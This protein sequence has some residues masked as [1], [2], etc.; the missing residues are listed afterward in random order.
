MAALGTT[1]YDERGMNAGAV[2]AGP[3]PDAED[4]KAAAETDREQR[5]IERLRSKG[6]EYLANEVHWRFLLAAYEG[7]PNYVTEETLFKHQREHTRDFADRMKRA[8]YQNYCQPLVDFVPEYIFSQ[9]V[10]R[11]P[12]PEL[13]AQFDSFKKNCDRSGS[14]LDDFMQS[15]GE[16][17]RIF[18]MSFIQVDKLPTPDGI[19]ARSL[20][21]K[22]AAELGLDAPYFIAIRPLEVLKWSTDAIGNY[23]YLKRCEYLEVN[24]L[25]GATSYL[26]RYTEWT[27]DFFQISIVDV[28]DRD[29][30][31]MKQYATKTPHKWKEIPFVPVFFKRSK[32][33]NDVGQSLLQDIG[34]QNRHVF[35][36]TSLLDE[37]LY[38][39]CFNMLVMPVKSQVPT[40]E[41]V[42]GDMGTSNVLEIP[43]DAQHKPEYLSPP[44][45]PAEFIQAERASTIHEM[46]RQAAQDI[47]Q[48]LATTASGDASKQSFSRTVPVINKTADTLEHAERRAFRLWAIMQGKTF[49]D[50]KVS[51]KDDYS[52]TNLLDLLIQ[53]GMIFGNCKMQSP[54]FIR[55]E[56]K[57]IVR[58]FDGK[59]DKV[60]M[61]KIVAEINGMSDEDIDLLFHPVPVA[62]PGGDVKAGKG[63]PATGDLV[64]GKEQK[65][66]GTD[67]KIG[68]AK[69]TKA[70]TKEVLA[71]R[72][73]RSTTPSK[74][75]GSKAA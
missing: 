46:Y 29:K 58:E 63:L 34:Y 14:S 8:H 18:G 65:Q 37:F 19:D 15:L 68:G 52:V 62:P 3:Q 55:E 5:E 11:Q 57:R 54:T 31:K 48:D 43:A 45:A 51:Y 64:Q 25:E 75:K 35:N 47:M 10:E 44:V 24:S 1:T 73:K 6:D 61:D 42:E 22:Q 53:L 9:G 70:G 36:L 12:P 67:K 23:T 71:D 72:N 2:F 17:I 60:A 7:G 16:D 41:Q 20:S 74:G 32:T 49:A 59:L 33:N 50:G 69:G 21:V 39:Q 66:L 28:A 4:P 26:E 40:R 27:P 13:A 38:R 56:W 30:P